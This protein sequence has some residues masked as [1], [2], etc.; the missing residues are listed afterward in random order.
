MVDSCAA[1][2]DERLRPPRQ[3][4][5]DEGR[6]LLL[7]A[8][9]ANR[10]PSL[11]ALGEVLFGRLAL[12]AGRSGGDVASCPRP[13][14]WAA[15]RARSRAGP[16]SAPGGSPTPADAAA[17]DR[18]AGTGIWC[19]C[20]G[21]PHGFLSI[22]AH[23]HADAL[24]VEVRYG[25][26]DI[27]AD[28]GTYCYHGEPAWRSYFR[29]TLAHNTAELAG[30]NQSAEGGPFLWL[31]HATAK[32]TGARDDGATA[33]W[34]ADDRYR[35]LR[36]PARHRRLVRLDRAARTLEI[37]DEV[38]AEHDIQLAFHLGP[39]V[40]AELDGAAAA[41]RWPDARTPGRHGCSYP[42]GC[43]GP[44]PGRDGPHPW[45]VLQ[46]ARTAYSRGHATRPGP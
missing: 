12:V 21:G 11:L 5:G 32:E 3:G 1:L 29:S 4:D 9:V 45:L 23:A 44:A 17:H 24:S 16:G 13:E 31:R 46:R 38:D 20:D 40:L 39:D 8:P 2:V 19:R 26:V 6:A 7:D 35:S 33:I 22:A 15:R 18:R 30:E 34:A 14:R 10:W 28:P 37:T 43:D 36:P 41:L 42:A 25:G 27:L